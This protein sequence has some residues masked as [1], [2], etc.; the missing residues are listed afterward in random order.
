MGGNVAYSY[1]ANNQ[2]NKVTDARGVT[3]QY[4]Y[5]GLG[6]LVSLISPDSGTTTFE[7]DDAGNVVRKT[8]ARGVVSLFTYDALNRLK[9]VSYPATPTLSVQMSYDMTHDGNRGVGRLTAIQDSGGLI[10]YQYD[11]RGNLTEQIRSVPVLARTIDE[12]VG[13]GYDGSN[14]ICGF[15][16]HPATHSMSIWPPIP[17]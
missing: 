2:I 7:H 4:N 10:G 3:T 15:H 17:R 8:D 5:D 16:G 13:Y 11:P 1:N 9:S 6:N 14:Q 12:A